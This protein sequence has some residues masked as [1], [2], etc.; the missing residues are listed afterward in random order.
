[1]YSQPGK[2]IH[3]N[4]ISYRYWPISAMNNRLSE[5]RLKSLI[6]ASLLERLLSS[7]L[8]LC[9]QVCN[10]ACGI[11]QTTDMCCY[12]NGISNAKCG[13][14]RKEYDTMTIFQY[15]TSSR[16]YLIEHCI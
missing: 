9:V 6:G 3:L 12:G 4:Q 13:P 7:H 11:S 5:Y 16:L 1:M 2:C 14:M 15:E 10:Y 8:A